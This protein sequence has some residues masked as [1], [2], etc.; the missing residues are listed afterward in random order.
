MVLISCFD[1]TSSPFLPVP[2]FP[3]RLFRDIVEAWPSHK[4]LVPHPVRLLPQRQV[5]DVLEITLLSTM[6]KFYHSFDALGQRRNKVANQ[7]K[8]ILIYST[9]LSNVS[10]AASCSMHPFAIYGTEHIWKRET[11]IQRIQTRI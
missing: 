1:S 10:L 3:S 2:W 11:M 4:H 9:I 7:I 5:A 6:S 8:E